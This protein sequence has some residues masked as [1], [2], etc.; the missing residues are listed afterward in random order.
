[1]CNIGDDV[2]FLFSKTEA[3][4]RASARLRTKEEI[5]DQAD[6]ILRLNWACVNARI[7][8]VPPPGGLNASVVYER[9]Y[10]LNWLIHFQNQEWD[11]VT[12]ST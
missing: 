4:F 7:K 3:E 11:N 12:T 9:H 5:L 10:A 8:N 1:M 6:L 2:G